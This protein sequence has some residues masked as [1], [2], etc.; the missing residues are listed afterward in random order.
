MLT[1]SRQV[2]KSAFSHSCSSSIQTFRKVHLPSECRFPS[3]NSNKQRPSWNRRIAI[4][5]EEWPSCVAAWESGHLWWLVRHEERPSLRANGVHSCR[6]ILVTEFVSI[7]GWKIHV[8]VAN[9]LLQRLRVS[10]TKYLVFYEHPVWSFMSILCLAFVTTCTVCYHFIP[11]LCQ[12]NANWFWLVLSRAEANCAKVDMMV[13][14]PVLSNAE[15]LRWV[16]Q[17]CHY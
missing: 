6:L 9:N 14:A 11:Y 4:E 8:G 2:L 13:H 1:N 12:N 15:I 3:N 17:A 10:F 5:Q 16:V 7:V